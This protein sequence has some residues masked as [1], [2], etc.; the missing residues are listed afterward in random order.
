LELHEQRYEFLYTDSLHALC[1][2]IVK[3]QGIP[4]VRKAEFKG[5]EYG[6]PYIH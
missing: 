3:E 5:E 2:R 1:T 6:S 4:Q